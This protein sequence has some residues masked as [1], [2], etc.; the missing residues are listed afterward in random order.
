M[1]YQLGDREYQFEFEMK[2]YTAWIC[3]EMSDV[4][5]SNIN[6]LQSGQ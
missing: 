2:D 3:N 4:Y 6:I 5:V 1:K